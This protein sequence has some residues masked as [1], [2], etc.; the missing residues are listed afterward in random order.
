MWYQD[1]EG[2]FKQTTNA[3]IIQ[4]ES[5]FQ[6]LQLWKGENPMNIELGIDYSGVFENRVFLTSEIQTIIEKYQ[7]SFQSIELTNIETS[8]DNEITKV[9]IK[10]VMKSGKAVLREL[11]LT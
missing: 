1:N 11:D 7:N 3:E 10:I 2:N 4:L 5:L 6:E 9:A 8:S